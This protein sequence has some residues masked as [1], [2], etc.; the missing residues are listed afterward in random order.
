MIVDDE[1]EVHTVTRMVV[2]DFTFDGRGFECISAYTAREGRE[3]IR[4]HPDTALI[5]LDVVMETNQAGLEYV[6]FIREELDNQLV[7]IILR[8]GQPGHA[9]E[10]QVVVQYDINDY[11]Q[12]TELTEERL[13]TTIIGAVRSYKDLVTI[14]RSM[15]GL[16]RVIESSGHLLAQ[17][18]SDEFCQEWL[19]A[20]RDLVRQECRKHAPCEADGF[21]VMERH[22]EMPI[23]AGIGQYRERIGRDAREIAPDAVKAMHSATQN[24]GIQRDGRAFAVSFQG[25]SDIPSHVYLECCRPLED[26]EHRLLSILG[27]NAGMALDNLTLNHEL[28][29]TQKELIFTLGDV[30]ESRSHETANHVRRVAEYSYYLAME[31]GLEEPEAGLLRLASPMHDVGKIGIPDSILLKPGRLTKEEFEVMKTH[32]TIGYKILSTSGRK[33]IR[34]A[35]VVALQHHERWDGGGYPNGLQGEEIHIFGRITAL[36][37]VFDALSSP[38][39]YK[40]AWETQR[41]LDLLRKERGGLFEPALVD[42][43]LSNLDAIHAIQK[44][45]PDE[46]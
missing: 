11:K 35:A 8:T 5:L 19:H 22:G 2:R 23:V 31:Y 41:I 9:P 24:G 20:F 28:I 43:L 42:L 44:A 25:K 17:R 10:R 40:E 36:A 46:G 30:V 15:H 3:L 14:E 1:E 7:R 4:Q 27:T 13:Y 45:Y 18:S 29:N 37:D 21:A 33:I 12:K 38:R 26:L 34:S 6:K 32:T 39:V 16:E